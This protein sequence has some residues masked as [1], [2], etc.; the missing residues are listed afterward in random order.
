MNRFDG[1]V[2]FNALSK[3]NLL[4]IVD[5]MIADMNVAIAEKDLHLTVTDDVKRKIVDL[6]YNPEMGARPLR[7]VIQERLEDQIAD[8]YLDNPEVKQ[9]TTKL[10]DDN[11]VIEEMNSTVQ[12]S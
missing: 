4:K 5:L 11:I 6:G 7:R 10:V 3:D 12:N 1:I 8:F 2:E 9:L